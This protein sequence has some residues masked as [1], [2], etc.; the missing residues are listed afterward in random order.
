MRAAGGDEG[1][2][3]MFALAGGMLDTSADWEA[4]VRL[5]QNAIAEAQAR[6]QTDET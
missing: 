2:D 3:G 6:N 4:H 5:L 1:G